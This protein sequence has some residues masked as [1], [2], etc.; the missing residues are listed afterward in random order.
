MA[1]ICGR[2][3]W[4]LFPPQDTP[5]MYATR[6]PY[7]ESSVFSDVPVSAIYAKKDNE[8]ESALSHNGESGVKIDAATLE[9]WPRFKVS[10]MKKLKI[11]Y[12]LHTVF[13]RL[14][15]KN[16]LNLS[17]NQNNMRS[18][19]K[20]KSYHYFQ[21]A[22][23]YIVTLNPGDVLF[24]PNKWWHAVEC[25]EPSISVNTWIELDSDNRSR[26]EEAVTRQLI[27]SLL[28][29]TPQRAW[30]NPTEVWILTLRSSVLT[31]RHF[32]CNAG[33]SY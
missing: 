10:L 5:N 20:K 19:E 25:L 15:F 29:K 1:Q 8:E 28:S 33:V 2:K 32:I 27:M 17:V 22:Q 6:V 24:V 18:Y 3:R 30:L 14:T 31:L 16:N 12:D 4:I 13:L 7:E 21:N 9:K 11:L 23:P 26:L